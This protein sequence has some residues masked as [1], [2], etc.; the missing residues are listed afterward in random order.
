[1]SY[2]PSFRR[3]T[4]PTDKEFESEKR[5]YSKTVTQLYLLLPFS[6]YSSSYIST[7]INSI[8]LQNDIPV[9]E[10]LKTLRAAF[11][12]PRER[13]VSEDL[14]YLEK[15]A[16][17]LAT[18]FS[19]MSEEIMEISLKNWKP[20]V[21]PADTAEGKKTLAAGEALR[22][23]ET[24][25]PVWESK[26]EAEDAMKAKAEIRPRIQVPEDVAMHKPLP[27]TEEPFRKVVSLA[28]D[29]ILRQKE[30]FNTDGVRELLLRDYSFFPY[31]EQGL[32]VKIGNYLARNFAMLG[33]EMEIGQAR[34]RYLSMY[35]RKTS[36][37]IGKP[38]TP[39]QRN[40]LR[41]AMQKL[42]RENSVFGSR[43][44]V[45]LIS[46]DPI[47]KDFSQ[48]QLFSKVNGF[49]NWQA[50]KKQIK[51]LGLREIDGRSVHVFSAN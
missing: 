18:T 48:K 12:T 49:I 24:S 38:I 22:N 5:R 2:L 1:M 37:T 47:F 10:F 19:Q 9:G 26:T 14:I 35:R 33:L 7:A 23:P 44:V 15:N 30:R 34:D 17:S 21:I 32:S 28:I 4:R 13:K 11:Q 41:Y 27:G 45:N 40:A 6:Q 8:C 46:A 31:S 29:E 20:Y 25:R 16:G 43:D 51:Y 50:V 39:E 3:Q 36:S 42:S